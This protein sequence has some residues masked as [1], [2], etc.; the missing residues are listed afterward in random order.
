MTTALMPEAQA[1]DIDKLDLILTNSQVAIR[2][3]SPFKRAFV[4]AA[5]IKQIEDAI[6]KP[7]MDDIMNLM[8][9]PIGFKTDRRP[10]QKDRNGKEIKPYHETTVKRCVIVAL[11]SGAEL[12][13]NQFNIIAGN[14]YFTKEFFEKA[15]RE[16]PGISHI[17][18]DIGAAAQHG[19]KSA[20]LP[21]VAKWIIGGE[22]FEMRFE[23]TEVSDMRIVVNSHSASGPDQLR[24][25]AE[26]KVYRRVYNRI[27]GLNLSVNA[28]APP[29]GE[30]T[31]PEDPKAIEEKTA[32]E[33]TAEEQK[34]ELSGDAKAASAYSETAM[35]EIKACETIID[36]NKA[37]KA[38][39][40]ELKNTPW[41][42]EVVADVTSLI[43]DFTAEHVK[44]IRAS[45]GG[46]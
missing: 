2:D 1:K 11:M 44:V 16:F 6:T 31:P 33:K 32:E 12:S 35:E 43:N 28:D 29:A 9:S 34:A 22:E 18:I 30:S 13:G 17:S 24:G 5:A 42:D 7:M 19:A 27:S 41:P 10:G 39:I 46:N 23:K 26:S 20:A 37:A 21:A 4:L 8:N 36:T 38:R 45:R 25:L 14:A 40:E 3:A 15:V